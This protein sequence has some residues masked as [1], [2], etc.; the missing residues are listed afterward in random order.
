MIL[1]EMSSLSNTMNIPKVYDLPVSDDN[2]VPLVK[3]DKNIKE[4]PATLS[5]HNQNYK[6]NKT[7][8]FVATGYSEKM[9]TEKYDTFDRKTPIKT[10]AC[11]FVIPIDG[12][13]EYG[14]CS[15][16]VCTFAHSLEE[17][18]DP[19]CSFD[20]RCK[21]DTCQFRHMSES[22][23]EWLTRTERTLPNLPLTITIPQ[24]TSLQLSPPSS[25]SSPYTLHE[26]YASCASYASTPPKKSIEKITPSA[27]KKIPVTHEIFSPKKAHMYCDNDN[28]YT[29]RV[30]TKELAEI[31]I[32][33]AFNKG[34]L[35]IKII[36]E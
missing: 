2:L 5:H 25:P 36:I 14:V 29:V 30:P 35:N 33:A 26:S 16:K 31:A 15:R 10:K 1:S 7:T 4:K 12:S 3:S 17:L 22:R 24:D 27:P 21:F 32:K 34:I 8:F 19:M 13:T 6:K 9:N 18:N 11:H 28:I 20:D 23:S